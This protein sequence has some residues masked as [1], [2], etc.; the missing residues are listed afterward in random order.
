[1]S[2]KIKEIPSTTKVHIF[3]CD[4]CGVKLMES[5]EYDD[6][7]YETPKSINQGIFVDSEREWY[8]YTSG[9]LCHDCMKKK[10][11]ALLVGLKRLGFKE[12]RNG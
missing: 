1:M 2:E 4:D 8:H 9:Y 10:T 3:F 12:D 7:W 5:E 11:D 6:G